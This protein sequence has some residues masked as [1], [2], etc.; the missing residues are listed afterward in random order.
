MLLLLC[1]NG[2][3][4][5]SYRCAVTGDMN[6]MFNP[7]VVKY[8]KSKLLLLLIHFLLQCS[9]VARRF[10]HIKVFPSFHSF[11]FFN[12]FSFFATI[13]Y[14]FFLSF[15]CLFLRTFSTSVTIL[16]PVAFTHNECSFCR[17]SGMEGTVTENQ[18]CYHF[19]IIII[20]V[21][22]CY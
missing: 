17:S 13:Y 12:Y 11:C 8:K 20:V 15:F 3:V 1:G 16:A 2:D 22:Y 10:R 7:T 5:Y 4:T 18:R 9:H 6:I 21:F 19:I 14:I